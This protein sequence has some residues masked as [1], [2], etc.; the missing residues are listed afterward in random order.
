MQ[1]DSGH[2][3]CSWTW[4]VSSYGAL[5]GRCHLLGIFQYCKFLFGS[6]LAS[7]LLWHSHCSFLH[8]LPW[9]QAVTA[10]EPENLVS[11]FDFCIR[12]LQAL[13]YTE[14]L[15]YTITYNSASGR[16]EIKAV[17]SIQLHRT[18]RQII[19]YI[20]P[21]ETDKF[22]SA[23]IVAIDEAAAIPLPLV[24]SLMNQP[25]RLTFMS[26][27]DAPGTELHSGDARLSPSYG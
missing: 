20:P 17:V 9:S 11:V 12:G 10:P 19:Q 13:K 16:E 15:D 24:R 26:S 23:E 8:C 3:G 25:D 27:T 14:H 4:Q 7:K 2:D 21:I 22:N 5:F 6:T 1:V 18:H